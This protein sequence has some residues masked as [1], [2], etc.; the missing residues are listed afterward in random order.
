M[1]SQNYVQ[2]LN[3]RNSRLAQAG[4]YL[5]KQLDIELTERCNNACLHCYINLS[6]DD[7]RSINRELSTNEWKDL[8][9]QAYDLGVI[10]IRFTGGEPLLREDFP[11]LYTFTRKLGMK[12]ILFTN[13][14]LVTPRLA[15]LFT[16]IPP[17]KKIEIS[18][19]GIQ[20]K[21]YENISAV[22][23]SYNEYRTGI[24]LLLASNIPIVLKPVILPPN[25]EDIDTFEAVMGSIP[26]MKRNIL[27]I[28]LLDLRA[29][30]DS[31]NKNNVIRSL[32]FSPKKVVEILSRHEKEYKYGMAVFSKRY[33]FPQGNQLFT[34]GAG[35]VGCIDA[36]GTFQVCMML[37]HPNTVYDLSKGSVRDA[38]ENFF[39][40]VHDLK[41][42]NPDY[43]RRCARCFLKGL[44]EQCPAKSW[45]EHGSLDEPVDYLCQVAHA[46][47]RFLGILSEHE[48]SWEISN[49]L[50]RLDN[51]QNNSEQIFSSR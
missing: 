20:E 50:Q 1:K 16:R 4:S 45:T 9:R 15:D 27:G 35:E 37:R 29:R 41:A 32:R 40:T 38:V 28:A 33:L 24:Q 21:T 14:R 49:W 18:A 13:A 36:Y 42:S 2:K 12:V 25:L 22:S 34:C 5:P 11:E 7:S 44:C 17:L 26:G 43:L 46:Q 30:H 39:P 47:A 31:L 48:S 23:G 19:Y 10:T 6:K 51:F 3:L 8:I